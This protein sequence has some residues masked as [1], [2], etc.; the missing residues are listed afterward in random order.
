MLNFAAPETPR[1]KTTFAPPEL[2]WPTSV[3]VPAYPPNAIGSG[4][5]LLEVEV[6]DSGRVSAVRQV[7]PQTAFDSAAGDAAQR[8]VFR[9]AQRGNRGVASRVVLIFSFLATT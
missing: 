7:T 4:K 3:V 6:S 9:P 5:V 1:Y 8:W 2:P